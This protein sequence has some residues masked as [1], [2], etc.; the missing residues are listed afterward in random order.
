MM[1]PKRGEVWRVD[2]GIAGKVRPALVVSADYGDRDYA[3]IAV[4]PHTT[5]V[6]GSSFEVN[7]PLPFLQPG[8]FNIQGLAPLSPP[9]FIQRLGSA[10]SQQMQQIS[11]ALARWMQL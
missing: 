10:D 3:L 7:L 8:V 4:V 1:R 6:R 5:S 9:R 2:L 11:A